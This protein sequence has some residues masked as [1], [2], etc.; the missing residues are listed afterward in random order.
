MAYIALDLGSTYTKIALIN[1]SDVRK[2]QRLPTPPRQGNDPDRYEIDA[3]LYFSQILNLLEAF[4]AD[5]VQGIL[6]STQMHGWVLTDETFH[7]LTP[8]VSWQDRIG[9][10]HLAEIHQLLTAEDVVPSGVP[11]KANLAL[12]SLWGRLQE[13]FILP[14]KARLCTLGGYLIGRLTKRHACHMTNAAPTGLVDVQNGSWNHPLLQKAGLEGLILPEIIANLQPVG[15]WRSI[16]VY[17]DLGD[18]Q[19][20]A[21]GAALE[22]DRCL[23]VSIGTAGLIGLLTQ[24]WGSG[25]YENRPWIQ[26]GW[27]LRT[28]SGLPGGRDLAAMKDE[29]AAALPATV[30]EDDVWQLMSTLNADHL[31]AAACRL[32]QISAFYQSIS[33]RYRQAGDQMERSI[34]KLTFSGG[35][36]AKNPE[37]RRKLA[38]AF[39]SAAFIPVDHD[40]MLGFQTIIAQL[41][42]Y[43]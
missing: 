7:P 41:E 9:A 6:L 20:C 34:D 32:D 4:S 28:V 25:K 38:Q 33:L 29:L 31:P 3:E 23:H 16:P 43:I 35:A 2:E 30:P 40:V 17:P 10:K 27:Y 15:L 12:C 8:Y 18:Q 1:R 37:L 26:P 13:G 19:T 22:I 5:G 24:E 42:E 39:D 36:A 14:P 21:A 11:L